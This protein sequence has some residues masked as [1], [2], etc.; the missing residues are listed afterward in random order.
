MPC[1]I[2]NSLYKS[3]TPKLI[4]IDA[5]ITLIYIR[6]DYSVGKIIQISCGHSPAYRLSICEVDELNNFQLPLGVIPHEIHQ[7]FDFELNA[8]YKNFLALDGALEI[9]GDF[10]QF[11]QKSITRILKLLAGS[12]YGVG[13]LLMASVNDIQ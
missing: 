3:I 8:S 2:F 12:E 5:L 9:R 7:Q 13:A 1:D 10:Y 6:P 11:Y 4:A